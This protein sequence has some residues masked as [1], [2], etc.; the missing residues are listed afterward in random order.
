M[1]LGATVCTARRPA[2]ERCPV[3]GL[4]LTRPCGCR[5]PASPPAERVRFE[6]TDRYV[7]GRIVAA[8]V[9]G[10]PLPAGVAPARLRRALDGLAS[11]GLVERD[12]AAPC[13]CRA[14]DALGLAGRA[15]VDRVDAPRPAR[16]LELPDLGR[17][18]LGQ[19]DGRGRAVDRDVLDVEL[20]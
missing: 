9:A 20:G 19:A 13:G 2:C 1:E 12:A 16:A 7:R 10:E 15:C 8:L 18:V 17:L 11:D 14:P 5:A 6:D 4:S 3:D